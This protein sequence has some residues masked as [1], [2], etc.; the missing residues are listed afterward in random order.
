MKIGMILEGG[1]C[2][3]A[4]SAGA[5]EALMEEGITADYLLG[6]SAGA[7]YMMSYASGQRGR[8][9]ELLLRYIPDRR[10]MGPQYMTDRRN[11][12]YFNLDFIYDQIP[13]YYLP[14]D[15]Q[16]CKAFPGEI[17]AVVT[18][19]R[20][21]AP[22]YLPVDRGDR[23][24]TLLRATCALPLLFP[25]IRYRGELY[26][27][28]GITDPIP[29]KRSVEA[30]CDKNILVL[31]QDRRYIKSPEKALEIGKM[32]YRDYP[33]F[34]KALDERTMRYNGALERVRKYE[35]E[36]K[37]FVIAPQDS[38]GYHRL[39]KDPELLEQWYNDGYEEARNRM[40]ALKAYLAEGGG[41][42][43]ESPAAPVA[44]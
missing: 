27:D 15:Y 5:I 33:A 38:S 8:N 41:S 37:V 16:A 1:A 2:R 36:G 43:G 40:D 11:R 21:G 18:N 17:K 10:Y 12:S 24:N 14:Y 22:E 39:E 35:A 42:D 25:P 23:R 4:F 28:G 30:G 26:M 6:V 32:R 3:A 29:V 19:L 31:T 7:C 13:N 34:V 44:E 20:T 9:K